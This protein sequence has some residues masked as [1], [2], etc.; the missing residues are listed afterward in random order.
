MKLDHSLLAA[1]RILCCQ[2]SDPFLPIDVLECI[3]DEIGWE[4]I[5]ERDTWNR[6]RNDYSLIMAIAG[7]CRLSTFSL[8]SRTTL[9]H[10]RRWKFK[11]IM[12]APKSRD[13]TYSFA[14]QGFEE[15][16]DRAL[17]FE[18]RLKEDVIAIFANGVVDC[19]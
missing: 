1:H 10:C 8:V 17:Q 4:S 9:H 6:T 13:R 3:I 14:P 12:V 2:Q 5:A 16:L 18:E 7:R 11:S 15:T 19:E